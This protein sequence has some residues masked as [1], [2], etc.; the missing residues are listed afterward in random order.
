MKIDRIEASKHKRGRV[1]VFLADGSL[2]KV[3]EQELLTFGL[4]AGDELDAETLERLKKAAGVSSVKTTAAD[5]IGRRAMSRRDLEKKLQEKGATEAEARYAGEWLE[6]IGALD[7]GAYA[8]A[9]VRHCGDM[10]YGP[11]RARE[12]LREKGVPQ[13]LW[14]EALDELP[15]EP[16][17]MAVQKLVDEFKVSG[18]DLIV[19][20]GGG[21]VMDAA[22]LASVLV[23]D[24]YGVKELLDNP[25]MAQKCVPIVLI[26]TTAGTGAEVTPNAI[27]A[28][29][30]K[31]LKVG[32][33]NENMIADYVI[34][35]ARMIKNLPRKIAA[36]TG[37]DALAHCIECFTSNKANPFS[38]LYALEGLDLILNNI[39]KACDDPEAM[40]EKNRMQIA[41]Y[42][43]GLAITASGT[44][45]VHALSYPLGGKYHIAHG[46]SNA[47]LL[48]PVM[49]F[50]SEHPAVRE[51]L[52]AAYDRCCHEEKTCTTVEEKTA[53]M[54]ARLEHIVKHLDIPTSLKEFGVPAEDLEGLVNAGMQVQRLLVNNMRPVTADDARKL[55]QEIM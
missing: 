30:E 10:G 55:Y 44:T 40:A 21:S 7:D 17:Y 3:T 11:R 22:K 49:R 37:V 5:L 18:A 32:I 13:E 25:G 42:Y 2:L 12:K 48:A 24:A 50:N 47:I 9:L 54:I 15:P 23:T 34:L 43:G 31:E 29:P 4:R 1:L 20:C 52:A 51:R 35:D 26:P 53:W 19:A 33:V 41:A 6:A 45:A 36:A 8:A 16:S 46:V 28:V 14:D 38:D 39:E 27:V